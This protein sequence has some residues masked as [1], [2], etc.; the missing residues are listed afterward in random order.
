MSNSQQYLDR[1]DNCAELA[2]EATNKPAKN[3]FR[4]MEAAWRALAAEQQWLD[5]EISPHYIQD[6]EDPQTMR[7]PSLLVLLQPPYILAC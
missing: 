1:A 6:I 7:G 5:G 4:R 2:A 3:R